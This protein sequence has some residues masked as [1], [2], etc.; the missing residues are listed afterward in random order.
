MRISTAE[1]QRQGS[2]AMLERYNDL[3]RT[4]DQLSSGVRI[5]K[6]SDDP[7]AMTE[8]ISLREVIS[9]NE[10]YN[11]NINAAEAR[12]QTEESALS[13]A[14]DLL[15]RI[16]ELAIQ[17]EN[18]SLNTA[19]R[20][21]IAQEVQQNL[22][23]LMSVANTRSGTGE[24]IFAGNNVRVEPFTETPPGTFNYTGD[25]GQRNLQIGATRQI[26]VGDPGDE[27]FMNTPV[28]GGGT[29]DI[30]TTIDNFV[31]ALQG[32]GTSPTIAA[33]IQLAID[34]ISSSRAKVGAR[35]NALDTQR[36][37]VGELIYQSQ[38][39]MSDLEDLD[40]AEAVSR[41]NLQSVA[42]QASQQSFNKI[43]NLSL[44]N[45]L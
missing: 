10:Q 11:K 28:S 6:P 34:H 31:T 24:Y 2:N 5:E 26:A 37:L 3:A 38:N 32:G 36:A 8:I 19:A 44:F 39:T 20:D 12:L 33:D 9:I 13:G 17:A 16:Y 35:L 1:M 4:Q 25:S 14:T 7:V 45:Y 23:S 42:L 40:F 21:A 41:L 27:T 29:Q 22:T 30:F 15:V 18:P 43:Q